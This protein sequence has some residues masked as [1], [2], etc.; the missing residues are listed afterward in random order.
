MTSS[1]HSAT[2]SI[3]RRALVA[4]LGSSAALVA[5]GGCDAGS[6]GSTTAAYVEPTF[7][8]PTGEL[9]VDMTAWNHDDDNDVWW[10]VGLAY[11]TSPQLTDYET[12]GLYVPGAYLTG[13]QNDDG[14]TWTCELEADGEA[15]DF[16]AATAPI[17]IPV[18]TA[19]YAAQAAPTSYSYD[20]VSAYLEA[21]F[22]YAY[23]GCRGRDNGESD[24]G[25]VTYAGGAPWGVTDLKAAIRWLRY[26]QALLPGD[27]ASIFTFGHS[28]GGAQSSLVGATGGS[29][30]YETYLNDIGAAM[31]DSAGTEISDVTCGAM[32]WCPIT[33]L[34][35]ADAAYEWQM[36]QFASTGTREEGTFTAQ[37]SLDLADAFASRVNEMGLTKDGEE[38]TLE[39]SDEGHYLSGTYAD[40]VV[41]TI[42]E[43]LA[44][45]IDDT[46]FPYTPS[47]SEMADGG[48]G[49]GLTS[50]GTGDAS[51]ELPDGDISDGELPEGDISDG[52]LPEGGPSGDA[53]GDSTDG[54]SSKGGS[55]DSTDGGPTGGAPV[56]GDAPEDTQGDVTQMSEDGGPSGDASGDS[57]DGGPTGDAA[58]GF[59]GGGDS[60]DSTDS[61]GDSESS[62][63]TY[64]T[65]DDYIASLNTDE[66][67]VTY[68]ESSGVSITGLGAFA[69]VVKAPTKDVGAFDDLSLSQAENK[70]FTDGTDEGCHFDPIMA[71]LLSENADT[72]AEL[73]NW[74]D[75]Y[76][77]AYAE[78]LEMTDALGL[79]VRDRCDMYNPMYYLLE[80]SDGYA[81]SIPAAH[82]RIR[83]GIT[84]GDTALTTEMNL[85][86]ALESADGV[87]DVDFATV[88]GQGHTT[89][90]RE[91][92]SDDNFIEWVKTCLS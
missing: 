3:S 88:W 80:S 13:T 31:E 35:E 52:E 21:G 82:W 64:E 48:F 62:E 14:E 19:G 23:P 91:G 10:Q 4:G 43:S 30:L 66:E 69:R 83:T 28:G 73:E 11:C 17:V 6:T 55:S 54:S 39:A 24:D 26:N 57:A 56:D 5:L 37:L 61:S 81:S 46:E 74:D 45:F 49:G 89:A 78:G 25:E 9:A 8:E 33:C 53:S 90:E 51:G 7:A 12:L 86:L 38:L 16:T 70:V 42:E 84:Q 79:T 22:V 58:G 15:G 29:A 76:P 27:T 77:D 44:N 75:S 65:A 85:A 50:G 1:P 71:D 68:D 32:C 67:W 47:T 72:Y 59:P 87:E 41:A 92:S 2:P 36:G 60:T 20:S 18:N 63:T 34:D 40:A